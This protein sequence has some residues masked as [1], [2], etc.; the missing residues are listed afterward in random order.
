MLASDGGSSG[1]FGSSCPCV[2]GIGSALAWLPTG[3]PL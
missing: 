2:G 3:E 1:A